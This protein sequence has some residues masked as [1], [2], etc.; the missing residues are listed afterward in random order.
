MKETPILFW[1]FKF[2]FQDKLQNE[3]V[4]IFHGMHF[5]VLYHNIA[6]NSRGDLRFI[7]TVNTIFRNC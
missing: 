3:L 6:Q 1:N 4:E 2:C 5:C 7:D